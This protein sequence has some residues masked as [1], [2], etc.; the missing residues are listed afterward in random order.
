MRHTLNQ[1]SPD[2]QAV[3]CEGIAK[4][5]LAGMISDDSVS[6]ERSAEATSDRI[7][8]AVLGAALLFARD[9]GQSSTTTMSDVLPACL[10]LFVA[11]KSAACTLGESQICS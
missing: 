1:D 9:S 4:L 7:V 3:A 10:F 2:V 6:T 5:M 11:G 8:A